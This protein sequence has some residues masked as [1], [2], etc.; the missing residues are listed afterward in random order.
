MR[1]QAGAM[2]QV[3]PDLNDEDAKVSREGGAAR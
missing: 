3:A 2:K 1:G